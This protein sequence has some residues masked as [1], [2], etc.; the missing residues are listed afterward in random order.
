VRAPE[1]FQSTF[2]SLLLGSHGRSWPRRLVPHRDR[3]PRRDHRHELSAVRRR[4]KA[5]A[6]EPSV[7]LHGVCGGVDVD[8]DAA[9]GTKRRR[10][11][12]LKLNRSG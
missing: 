11:G 8:A 6:L 3:R 9:Y 2:A 7:V 10:S 1:S 12:T 4:R 5:H